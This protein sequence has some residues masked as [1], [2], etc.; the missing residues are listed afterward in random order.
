MDQLI[1]DLLANF[2]S[3]PVSTLAAI[4]ILGIAFVTY[5]SYD[6]LEATFLSPQEE[7]SRFHRALESMQ[8]VNDAMTNLKTDT[9]ATAVTVYQF[10]N[11]KHDLTGIPFTSALV[12][13]STEGYS[14]NVP[15]STLNSSLRAVW[16]SIDKPSCTMLTAPVDVE[17]Q[18]YFAQY[19]LKSEILC[20]LV[21]PLNY[22]IGIVSVGYPTKDV[23]PIAIDKTSEVAKRVVGYLNKEQENENN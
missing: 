18:K 14:A 21:N 8:L 2:Y 13:F 12:T 19:K 5:K 6:K 11:G 20:P 17:S 23:A 10:H 9:S 1:K 4:L 15:M 22:P 16:T 7:A 3:R